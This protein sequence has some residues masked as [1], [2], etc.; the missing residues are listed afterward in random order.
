M[1]G[2]KSDEHADRSYNTLHNAMHSKLRVTN[3]R[4]ADVCM[5]LRYGTGTVIVGRHA[6]RPSFKHFATKIPFETVMAVNVL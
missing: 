5:L 3:V 2:G 6:G 4:I 1:S